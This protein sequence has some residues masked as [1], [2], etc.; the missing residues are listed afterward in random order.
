MKH[1]YRKPSISITYLHANQRINI[2][3]SKTQN[4]IYV[5]IT[6]NN[7]QIG[8]T[9]NVTAIKRKNNVENKWKAYR[10]QKAESD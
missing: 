4:G 8:L 2:K 1:F 5:F 7:K 3:I 6:Q 10:K 9:E